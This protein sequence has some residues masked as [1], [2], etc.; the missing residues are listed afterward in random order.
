MLGL[1]MGLVMGMPALVL[2][3]LLMR[4]WAIWSEHRAWLR[5]QR[6]Q[7]Q[8]EI[9]TILRV[10]DLSM[11]RILT[12]CSTMQWQILELR[13]NYQRRLEDLRVL[14]ARFDIHPALE[15]ARERAKRELED[16]LSQ[17]LDEAIDRQ[18]EQVEMY[19]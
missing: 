7:Q 11:N 14:A 15:P 19:S 12:V 13:E 8:H 9:E 10:A 3:I 17:Y 4:F 2:T 16:I 18:V 6:R 1:L 5:R